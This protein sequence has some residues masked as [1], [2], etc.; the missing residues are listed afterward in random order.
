MGLVLMIM[1]TII[2]HKRNFITEEAVPISKLPKI[3][4]RAFPALLMPAILLYGIYGGVTTPTEAAAIAAL[5]AL[6]LT[7]IFYRSVSLKSLYQIFV[8]LLLGT[9]KS[10]LL[11]FSYNFSKFLVQSNYPLP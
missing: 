6:F 8:D 10:Y 3:T 11:K 1:N 2:S 4:S 9:H 7:G 5:Y